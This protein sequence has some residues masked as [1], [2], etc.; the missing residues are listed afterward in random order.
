MTK[1]GNVFVVLAVGCVCLVLLLFTDL[2]NSN[3]LV[4]QRVHNV[5]QN[6]LGYLRSHQAAEHNFTQ[7]LT[8]S[9]LATTKLKH[10]DIGKSRNPQESEK[11]KLAR[12]KARRNIET[13]SATPR[14]NITTAS[15]TPR[16]N[17]VTTSVAT[18]GNNHF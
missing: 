7:I 2:S 11:K 15:A 14:R 3:N 8:E 5:K 18:T 12:N 10:L 1:H 9:I 16:R 13:A 17:I 4:I 6:A